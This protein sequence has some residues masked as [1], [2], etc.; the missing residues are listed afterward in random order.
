MLGS[1]SLFE[2]KLHALDN[3]FDS[4]RTIHANYCFYDLPLCDNKFK[5]CFCSTIKIIVVLLPA[6]GDRI[7]LSL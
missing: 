3:A 2:Y 5:F 7:L 1:E 4:V 6:Q